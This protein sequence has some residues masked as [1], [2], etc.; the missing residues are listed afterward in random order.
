MTVEIS[1]VAAT[2]AQKVGVLSDLGATPFKS[3]YPPGS[4]IV[5]V[6]DSNTD[7][8]SG[9]PGWNTAVVKEWY[10]IGGFLQGC[11]DV[12]LG[13]NGASISD[14]VA[15]IGTPTASTTLRLNP[16]AAVNNNPDLIIISLGTNE[17]WSAARR[18]GIGV[19]A[20]M[21]ANF[22][23]LV[24]FFLDNTDA[25]ILL[26]MPQ[27]FSQP[28]DFGDWANADAAAASSE[29]LRR[30]HLVWANRHPRVRLFDSHK[31]LF[32]YRVDDRSTAID[33]LTGNELHDDD[34]HLSDIG[35]RRLAQAMSDQITGSRGRGVT[36]NRTPDT[37]LASAKW[38][39]QGFINNVES[40]ALLN[41]PLDPMQNI[42][43]LNAI[44]TD[45][46]TS[47]P[48]SV[49]QLLLP[50]RHTQNLTPPSQILLS[51]GGAANSL[52]CWC[53]SSGK[54]VTMTSISLNARVTSTAGNYYDQ[55]T[56]NGP[57]AAFDSGDIGPCTW[58]VTDTKYI[59]KT[60]S[61]NQVKD[62]VQL[63]FGGTPAAGSSSY[64]FSEPW[65]S[66]ELVSCGALGAPSGGTVVFQAYYNG[67]AQLPSGGVVA[68]GQTAGVIDSP[69]GPVD[70]ISGDVL[71][72]TIVGNAGS[73]S[74][75]Y[76][77]FKGYRESY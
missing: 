40:S 12:N 58:F 10:S 20:T 38:A 39:M 36:V 19:E 45:Q 50:I 26:R 56:C 46:N 43:G 60:L 31:A 51:A 41:M 29:Q 37:I 55:F 16:N 42:G 2:Q 15:Q 22:N 76:F 13:A 35:Y 32:G 74:S 28:N 4:V 62:I 54:V 65:K 68:D 71:K 77:T 25:D 63:Q 24:E 49:Q 33:S 47:L 3:S 21:Q 64:V 67:V 75:A 34:L 30:V 59:P 17:L 57:S 14:W 9:R 44:L 53:H 1:G 73:G 70:F 61:R 72:I 7:N 18:A 52:S 5:Q 6:G 11:T 8:V 48:A 23:T 66:V 27:P 69:P